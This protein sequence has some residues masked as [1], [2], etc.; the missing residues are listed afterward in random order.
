MLV[1][2]LYPWQ[3]KKWQELSTLRLQS[4]LPHALLFCGPPKLGKR[5]FAQILAQTVLCSAEPLQSPCGHCTS[6]HMFASGHA[7]LKVLAP[8]EEGK[9][10]P[11]DELRDIAPFLTLRSHYQGRRIVII[12]QAHMM[13]IA[14]ANSVLKIL[15]EPP[16]QALLI[17]ITPKLKSLL[18]TIRSRCQTHVFTPPSPIDGQNWLQK[19]R[20]ACDA[21]L[22]LS[23]GGNAPLA[24]LDLADKGFD[25][26]QVWFEDF[27]ALLEARKEPIGITE[28]WLK[29][30]FRQPLYW[31][32]TWLMD[33][34][35]LL[36]TPS[37]PYL[38]NPD[39]SKV[40]L[41]YV[42]RVNKVHLH[43]V[44][45]QLMNLQHEQSNTQLLLESILIDCGGTLY[46]RR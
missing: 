9:R 37:P 16:L 4:R 23:L 15:E 10:I 31:L 1:N 30:D 46:V 5:H 28:S 43:K 14:G 7:D 41:D 29:G 35:R 24:A 6:C 45:K 2:D 25:Q 20:P 27:C 11:I 44:L 18:P 17:L 38:A 42:P 21:G 39:L 40:L 13:T 32:G 12:D 34:G 8:E 19:E 3:Q 36:V 33:L 22:L 26:R